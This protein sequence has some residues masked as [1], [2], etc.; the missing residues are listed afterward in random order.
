MTIEEGKQLLRDNWEKGIEC[1]C[2]KQWV[3]LYGRTM[4][5]S[6][7]LILIEMYKRTKPDEYIYLQEILKDLPVKVA[8]SGGHV[9][10]SHWWGLIEIKPGLREDGSSRVGWWKLTDKG[11]RFVLNYE[12]VPKHA[13]V[14]NNRLFGLQ[15]ERINIED[16]LR[17]KFDYRELMGEHY[18]NKQQQGSLL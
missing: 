9:T 3:Q 14:F 10:I 1:P 12:T 16:T 5:W 7:G 18:K 15:G 11:R 6:A 8:H 13:M 4:G 17:K 2:C